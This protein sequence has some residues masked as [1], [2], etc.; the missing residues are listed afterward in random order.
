[1]AFEIVQNGQVVESPFD[2][3]DDA[4]AALTSQRQGVRTTVDHPR[5]SIFDALANRCIFEKAAV[6]KLTKAR[7]AELSKVRRHFPSASWVTSKAEV[8]SL[9]LTQHPDEFSHPTLTAWYVREFS[10]LNHHK[11]I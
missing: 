11:E 10:C 5:Q 8:L 7:R 4:T 9:E 1:M 6:A 2:T 3:L